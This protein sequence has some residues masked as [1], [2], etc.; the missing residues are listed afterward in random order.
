MRIDF[1][2]V[3]L[4]LFLMIIIMC[5]SVF[6][7]LPDKENIEIKENYYCEDTKL[8]LTCDSLSKVNDNDIQTRC[9]IYGE[10]LSYKICKSG[11]RI[12]K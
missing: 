5:L 1:K 8:F 12:K 4:E 11:W 7:L 6:I 9:Y 2:R 10:V 3:T